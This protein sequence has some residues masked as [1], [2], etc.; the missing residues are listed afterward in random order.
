[1]MHRSIRFQNTKTIMV[2]GCVLMM[3]VACSH[4]S[5]H[6]TSRAHKPA[7]AST[8]SSDPEIF[9]QQHGSEAFTRKESLANI[10]DQDDGMENLD[11][12]AGSTNDGLREEPLIDEDESVKEVFS[13]D[14]GQQY[15]EQRRKAELLTAQAGLQDIFFAFDS[16]RLTERA[17]RI[18]AA[19]SEWLNAHPE[20]QVTIEGHCDERGTHA[21]NYAL[22][23]KRATMARNY[24]AALGV[25]PTQMAT[26]SYGKD[27][28][29]C[30]NLTEAC[31][32]QNRRAHLVLGVNVA[33]NAQ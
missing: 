7:K 15:W 1:M 25:S 11:N 23:E 17:K 14:S 32:E 10:N 28:P 21:Y 2:I 4:R 8:I 12:Q 9:S 18:L 31:F 33:S 24:L 19:N 27:N 16:W 13:S 26:V 22:G 6:G 5:I 3:T 30:Q 20:A 29:S